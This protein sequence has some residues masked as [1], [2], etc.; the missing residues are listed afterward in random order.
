MIRKIIFV[1][2]SLVS[3][4]ICVMKINFEYLVKEIRSRTCGLVVFKL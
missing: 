2:F 3:D 1:L 4:L